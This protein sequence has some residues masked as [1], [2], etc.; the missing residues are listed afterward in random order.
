MLCQADALL[1]A[2]EKGK[3][4]LGQFNLN[5][6]AWIKAALMAAEESRSPLIL[7]VT[8]SAAKELCGYETVAEMVRCADRAMG[9][10]V[11]VLLH[12]DHASL[13]AALCALKAGFLS[14]MY[15][16]SAESMETNLAN[17]RLLVKAARPYGAAVE[18]E[19]GSIAGQED[20]LDGRGEIATPED[21]R[22]LAD[23]GIEILAAGI[24]NMHGRY[25]DNWKGLDFE[26]LRRIREA[27]GL[28]PLALHGGSGV[29][30]T[31]L[32][33]AINGGIRKINVN[34]EC[35]QSY[36]RALATKLS[37]RKGKSDPAALERAGVAAIAETI[38]E[39]MALFGC[40]GKA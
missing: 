22:R 36:C 24:G 6:F 34:T 40:L 9:I 19:A 32:R 35:K 2:A 15:D 3:Y 39:K 37:C 26:A 28:L 14:V 38:R 11:P 5:G 30:E 18:A 31:M 12:A 1:R 10:H 16:G 29:P 8:E 21:C 4:A 23:C 25:P 27:T 20:G 17:T 13:D 33:R 7:G